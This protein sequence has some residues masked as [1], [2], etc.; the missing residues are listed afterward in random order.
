MREVI[1]QTWGWD[2]AWQR[3]DFDRRFDEYTV[4]IIEDDGRAAGGL[5]V[6]SRPDS[7]YI[8]ELQIMPEHQGRGFGTAVIQ[9]VI[10]DA[11]TRGLPVGLSVVPANPRAKR[12][13]ERL[14]FYVTAFQAPFFRM[15]HDA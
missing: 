1:E 14:G 11:A 8:H 4:S 3:R 2:Q 9:H 13:Y 5:L 15:R 10:S 12:L 7:I 6:E